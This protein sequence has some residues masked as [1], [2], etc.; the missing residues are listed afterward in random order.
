MLKRGLLVAGLI[1]LLDQ[2]TK[3]L[4]L[5]VV[6]VPPRLIEVSSFFNLV[7]VWN[8]GV[9]FGLLSNMDWGPWPLVA[10]SGGVVAGLFVWL[11]R[12]KERWLGL[13]LGLVIGG[14]L[15]NA[16][17]RIVFGAVFDFLDLHVAGYHWPA[18]NVADAA[19]SLGVVAIVADSLFGRRG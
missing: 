5:E 15:G 4:M 9:S 14:A 19:I 6:M 10:L 18:F 8:R 17:D 2:A 1:F 16:I 11:A 7:I 12:T 3:I 13:A